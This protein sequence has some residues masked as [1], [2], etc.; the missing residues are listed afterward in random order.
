MGNKSLDPFD[1]SNGHS[2][3]GQNSLSVAFPGDVTI[4]EVCCD[5]LDGLFPRAG[6]TIWK[7]PVI[8]K[9][10]VLL[11]ASW[12]GGYFGEGYFRVATSTY[13]NSRFTSQINAVNTDSNA[14]HSRS[15]MS[16]FL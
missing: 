5:L 4:D 1:K 15:D 16:R 3:A 7:A 11:I 8:L 12:T 2:S 10:K 13:R 9:F 6:G 14:N